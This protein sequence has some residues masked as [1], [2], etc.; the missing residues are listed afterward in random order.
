V[1]D[2][3]WQRL[4]QR[5]LDEDT[6][7]RELVDKNIA[8]YEWQRQPS[9][10]LWLIA[11]LR[12]GQRTQ[13]VE[14]RFPTR[15]PGECPAM[16][17]IPYGTR[18][19][20][21]QFGGD[22]VLCLELGPDN[23]HA[24]FMAADLLWSAWKLLALETINTIEPIPIPSRHV[25]TLGILV[26]GNVY[27]LVLTPEALRAVDVSGSVVPIE[28]CAFAEDAAVVFWITHA[29]AGALVDGLPPR[30]AERT[31]KTG[32]AVRVA[33]DA[34]TAPSDVE[35]FRAYLRTAGVADEEAA[36]LTGL[37]VLTTATNVLARYVP[38]GAD[39]SVKKVAV[40]VAA[41]G[42]AEE[43][44][45]AAAAASVKAKIAV[46]GLGS[47]GGKVCT[48][49][50]RSGVRTVAAIDGDVLLPANL[51]RHDVDFTHA[52]LMKTEAAAARMRDVA[53]SPITVTEYD[54][55]VVDGSNPS[56]HVQT[57]DA[58]RA[59]D[60]I[61]DA[62]ANPDAF[63]F[64]ADL[65]S[66]ER[67]PLVWG[68]IFAGGVG[69]Y[70]AYAAPDLTPCPS[71][72]RAAFLA[73]LEEL[74][75]APRAADRPYGALTADGPIIATDADVMVLAG[76]VTNVAQRILAGD[77]EGTKPIVVIGLRRGWIFETAFETRTFA[78]R[79]DDF[80][81]DRCWTKPGAPDDAILAEVE[82][83]LTSS[84]APHPNQP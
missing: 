60:L 78:V 44:I 39:A 4:P 79:R 22:G 31:R 71:C 35:G 23:W 13:T 55:D 27:R 68:E 9:G 7:L 48:S 12:L 37:V 21:H 46:V 42:A 45:G 73:H 66:Q 33:D 1:A 5:V 18:L 30:V 62:T 20:D 82:R 14:L 70:V 69:G 50:V 53:S 58:L 34:P 38:D 32:L 74:P 24:R 72:V 17:P 57:T 80:S 11:D 40:I 81:C 63:N 19:S 10:D 2:Q 75:P 28:Y 61:V 3:W 15:Y 26:R 56:I 54:H 25:D 77:L 59:A 76:A 8:S 49:L 84:D 41:T 43:R 47:L 83:L 6:R 52:G 36:K 65:A 29:P 64:L 51:L 67:R 16:R